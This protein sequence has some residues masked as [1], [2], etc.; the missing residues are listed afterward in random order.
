[1]CCHRFCGA[2]PLPPCRYVSVAAVC[3][4]QETPPSP[5]LRVSLFSSRTIG[6]SAA[7][8][9]YGCPALRQS[10]L[11][12]P[13]A[14]AP[15]LR[16]LS[17]AADRPAPVHLPA[18]AHRYGGTP[19]VSLNTPLAQQVSPLSVG[20]EP[21]RGACVHG[22]G[23][24]G[25]PLS[26]VRPHGRRCGR[27]VVLQHRGTLAMVLTRVWGEDRWRGDIQSLI[28]ALV[29]LVCGIAAGGAGP[30][31]GPCGRAHRRHPAAGELHA[32]HDPLCAQ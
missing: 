16:A 6:V 32:A 5:F 28:S 30:R 17:L 18:G 2:A 14:S 21:T 26:C 23:T 19:S 1:M 27:R 7:D 31:Y 3:A 13:A 24:V 20:V 12:S 29:T 22:G 9:R 8:R 11:R 25:V 4:N 10:V 15:Q